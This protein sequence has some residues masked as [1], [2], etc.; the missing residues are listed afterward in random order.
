M[1]ITTQRLTKWLQLSA[2]S[3]VFYT[4]ARL[5]FFIW[6]FSHYKQRS[7]GEI[8]WAFLLGWRFDVSAV[9]MLMAPL[10]L[11]L[12]I[13]WPRRFET[14]WRRV[15]FI[16]FLILQLPILVVNLVDTELINFVGRRFSYDA[17][18]IV[19][20]VPGKMQ[21]FFVS[22]WALFSFNT[23]LVVLLAT[24]AYWILFKLESAEPVAKP[25]RQQWLAHA[26]LC[27]VAVVVSVVGIRGG[28]QRKPLSFVHANVFAAPVLNNLVLNSTF[29]FI[30]SVKEDSLKKEIFFQD[31]KEMLSY[32]N[33]SIPGPSL[34][35][36]R[37]FPQ[38]Q[39]V[40]VIILESFGAEYFGAYEGRSYTPFL[41][42]LMEKSLV[43]KNGYA[44]AR[45][46]IEGV[47]AVMG[48]VPAM[49]NEPFIS[50][51]FMSNYFLGLGT[52]L[53]QQGYH[54]SFFHGANN[55]S[56][57]F[58]SFMQS[59]GVEHYYGSHE[60]PDASQHDGVWGIWD[61][62]FLQF[63]AQK[64]NTFP[65]PFMSSVFTLT[66]HQPFKV[67]AAYEKELPD[68]PLP[69]LKT[70][71][72]TDLALKKFFEAACKQPWYENTL[73]VITADHTSEHFRKEYQTDWGDYHVPLIF[74]HPRM[75][76]A[77]EIDRA[78]IAQQIDVMPSILDFLGFP[79]KDRNF[80]GS[81][82]FVKGDKTATV[83]IDGRYLL[84]SR[85]YFL[86]WVNGAASPQM[87]AS[88]DL[89]E[90]KPLAEPAARREELEKR[91][92]ASIQYF[93]QGMWDNKLYYPGY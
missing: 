54:T 20:E 65:Q 74:F 9:L 55:G 87:Y 10:L 43:M 72:Y 80:L 15:S 73:F 49:M 76:W 40:V 53:G 38:K 18:F 47:A 91:L 66:S 22:Y 26:F 75:Q 33:G 31:S 37:R 3:F 50:S 70:I 7:T 30:K 19:N 2:L 36:K 41:D 1:L 27:F 90:Q 68:G 60:F 34:M 62:P 46:S 83:F 6:N 8:L 42:S 56:M 86:K 24:G 78:Q 13:P 57:Y 93:N 59:A 52:L 82:I 92:K 89:L 14:S 71:A 63:M 79:E 51:H 25:T 67:P 23:L 64:L 21:N 32:L 5:E 88:Q 29:T 61:E 17:L 81:S 11:I 4:V 44:N 84:F 85:D 69:I 39:N 58:D 77:P 28:L 12:L 16:L 35:E 45:R 48:G